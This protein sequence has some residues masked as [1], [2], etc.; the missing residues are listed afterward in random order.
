MLLGVCSGRY[1]MVL[2]CYWY[3]SVRE[4][5]VGIFIKFVLVG[6]GGVVI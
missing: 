5:F 4:G 2:L 6:F 1:L 3:V